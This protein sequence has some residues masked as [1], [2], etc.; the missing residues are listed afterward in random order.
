MVFYNLAADAI[1]AFAGLSAGLVG[2]ALWP[3]V[4]LHAVMTVWCLASLVRN[5]ALKAKPPATM[6]AL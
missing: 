2:V 5:P 3:A 1:F 6:K 4:A